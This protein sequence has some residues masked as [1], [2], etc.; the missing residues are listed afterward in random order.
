MKHLA[1]LVCLGSSLALADAPE[2]RLSVGLKAMGG[3]SLTRA[4]TQGGLGGAV[5]AGWA[6]TPNLQLNGDFAWLVG[7][8]STTLL[9]LGAGWHPANPHWRPMVRADVELGFGGALDFSV[10]D[11]L[12]PRGPTLGVTVGVAPLRWVF[13]RCIVSVLELHGG[14]STEFVAVGGRF[15]L[16]LLSLSVPIAF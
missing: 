2:K 8:G 1:L 7:L 16:S 11:S 13:E 10:G 6:L 5:S 3:L 9:R 15:S 4:R 12:P 14:F